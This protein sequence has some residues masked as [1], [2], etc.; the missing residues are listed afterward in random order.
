MIRGKEGGTMSGFTTSLRIKYHFFNRWLRRAHLF[1][2]PCS[3]KTTSSSSN[4]TRRV[5]HQ[6]A[7][8]KTHP[9]TGATVR[10]SAFTTHQRRLLNPSRC[11]VQRNSRQNLPQPRRPGSEPVE[12]GNACEERRASSHAPNV[13]GSAPARV[14]WDWL[15]RGWYRPTPPFRLAGLCV[16][17]VAGPALGTFY[18]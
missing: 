11:R 6:R 9:Q 17:L 7:G 2:S 18:L 5:C 14:Q 16:C 15:E 13:I 8:H 12:T 1:G 10:E 4:T 3:L